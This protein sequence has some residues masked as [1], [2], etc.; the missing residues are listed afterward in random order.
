M[1]T[2]PG[3]ARPP[4]RPL[5]AMAMGNASLP[6]RAGIGT[7]AYPQAISSSATGP[8][9]TPAGAIAVRRWRADHHAQDAEVSL[10]SD[11]TV[12]GPHR[13]AG[14]AVGRIKLATPMPEDPLKRGD[15]GLF[16]TTSGGRAM[17]TQCPHGVRR[18]RFE[19]ERRGKHGWHDR[20]P[21]KAADALLQTAETD[22]KAPP[23]AGQPERLN[24]ARENTMINSLWI[25]K[26]G[27]DRPADA[28][29]R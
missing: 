5:D 13:R 10:G 21:S 7:E 6:V 8:V 19:R 11:G 15:D 26:T 18:W 24:T 23:A 9:L 2:Y 28:A 17:T 1:W 12:S 20:P 25:A 29:G 3:P 16:R 14:Q 27:A 22:D 4:G